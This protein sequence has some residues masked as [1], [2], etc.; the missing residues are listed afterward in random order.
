MKTQRK[1]RS[2]RLEAK[3]AGTACSAPYERSK[4]FAAWQA[5]RS[6]LRPYREFMCW[7]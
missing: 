4:E 1:L 3:A 6:K 2:V 7:L 5:Q